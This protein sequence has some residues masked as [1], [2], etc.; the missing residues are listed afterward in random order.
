MANFNLIRALHRSRL[1][2]FLGGFV[3]L[4]SV[5]VA[6]SAAETACVLLKNDNVIYGDAHQIGEYVVIR[7]GDQSELRL[8]RTAVACW[9]GSPRDLY[10]YRVDRRETDSFGVHLQDAQWCL[11]NDLLDLAKAELKAANAIMPNSSEVAR[12][13]DRINRMNSPVLRRVPLVETVVPVAHQEVDP[14]AEAGIDPQTIGYFA[15]NVQVTLVNRCGNCHAADTGRAWTI[16]S[17]P[18]DTRASAQMTSDNLL[19]A[20]PFVASE[21]PLSS[22][23]IIN[24]VTAHGG[25][26][27]PLGPRHAKAVYSL[28]LWL[29]QVGRSVRQHSSNS[30]ASSMPLSGEPYLAAKRSEPSAV[31]ASQPA[32]DPSVPNRMPEVED[33]FDPDLFNRQFHD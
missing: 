28:R 3:V 27:A 30:H 31:M 29:L 4:I 12:I 18:G 9:A 19:A 17:P 20:L 6:V 33:P 5:P 24:A 7:R 22:P 21:D 25:A 14:I 13:E 8:P 32:S 15:R 16:Q 23:L 1:R 10:R 11:Q 2:V 26:A